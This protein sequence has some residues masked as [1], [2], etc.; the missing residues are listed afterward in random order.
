MKQWIETFT[1]S[2]R[3]FNTNDYRS[4]PEEKWLLA[5]L[6]NSM[7]QSCASLVVLPLP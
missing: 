2:V 3:T 1:I 4:L 5:S 6:L 7:I